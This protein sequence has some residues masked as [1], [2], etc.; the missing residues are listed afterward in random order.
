MEQVRPQI[1]DA[2]RILYNAIPMGKRPAMQVLRRRISE[3]SSA[4]SVSAANQ[5]GAMSEQQH[6]AY[7]IYTLTKSTHSS[8][9]SAAVSNLGACEC[10][11]LG[12]HTF[13]QHSRQRRNN[14][15]T[16]STSEEP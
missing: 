13:V 11:Q 16:I 8:S 2:R 3:P 14:A 7:G 15:Y 5:S 12:V 1:E 4:A 10:T 9:V 6:A